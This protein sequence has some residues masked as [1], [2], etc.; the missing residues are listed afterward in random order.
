MYSEIGV[1]KLS[2]TQKS[3]LRNMHPTRIKKGTT[4]TLYLTNEQIK[5]L[6]SAAK[7]GKAITVTLN[8]DQA[9]KHG[10]GIFGDIGTRLKRLAVQNKDLIN[11]IIGRVRGAA[12]KG[13]AKLASKADES[14]D[15]YITDIKGEGIKR[16]GRPKKKVGE[17]IIGDA[18]KGLIGMSGLGIKKRGRPKAAA[19]GAGAKKTKAKKGKGILGTLVKAIAPAVID[20]AAGAAKGKVQGM[21]AQKK[22]L[23][24]KK[25]AGR[26]KKGGAL[27]AAGY[28]G[29][30]A[31]KK[32]GRPKKRGGA[33]Y[34][35][36]YSG[37]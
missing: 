15:K 21:G 3:R 12:K 7:K 22:G 18:I 14:I 28:S 29:G 32:V 17:G 19:K 20:A 25:K 13:V 4:N 16:R 34:A 2:E 10:S 26:P 11:P 36:G 31:K 9:Q 24:I 1:A 6:E 27:Y 23:G 35:A 8:P 30:G 5:K 37:P 33:L